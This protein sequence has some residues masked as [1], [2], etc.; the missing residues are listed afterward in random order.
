MQDKKFTWKSR[1]CSFKYAF[2][3]I[4]TL[5][6]YEHNARIHLLVTGC[7]ILAGFLLRLSLSEWTVIALAIGLVIS[8]EAFNSA[9]EALADFVSPD[10]REKI[11]QAKDLAA[12]GVLVTAIAAA[13]VGLIIFLPKIIAFL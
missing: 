5:I 11:K 7:V 4:R 12:G 2:A 8:A 10:Y 3:G 13:T 6:R 9:I 1:L